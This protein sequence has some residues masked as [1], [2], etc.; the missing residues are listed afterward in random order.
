MTRH[1]FEQALTD[2]G[3]DIG[4]ETLAPGRSGAVQLRF[5]DGA[6]LGFHRQD[7]DV[8]LHW[9]EPAPY[10]AC[11]LLLRAFKRVGNTPP[12]EPALQVGLH[13]AGGTDYLVLTTRLPE[14]DCGT[15]ELHQLTN[16]LRQYVAALRN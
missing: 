16:W 11:S 13:C 5:E 12:G 9:A 3:R 7:D 10:D 6:T 15:R 1:G 4:V 8:L 14:Q 2:F